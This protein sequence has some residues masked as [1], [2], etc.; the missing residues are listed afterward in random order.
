MKL[1]ILGT[2]KIVQAV[3]P[4]MPELK[5]PGSA[6]LATKRSGERARA[7][8]KDY[9]I[10]QIFFDYEELL[11]SDIDTVYVAL[12]NHLH[13]EFAKKA[14]LAGKHV[15]LEKPAA[16]TSKELRNLAD[17]A[18]EHKVYILEATNIHFMPAFKALKE[19][20]A[21]IGS[22]RIASFNY[23]QYSSRYE[24]FKNGLVHPVFDPEK[25]GGSLMDINFYNIE[26]MLSLFGIPEEIHYSANIER[27]IDT[28]GI[29]L[30]D[31]P[32]F[33]AVCIGA[34]D[35]AARASSTIQGDTATIE[36][37]Q[38]INFIGSYSIVY[39]DGHKE[40]RSFD[41]HPYRW[42]YEFA[43]FKRIIDEHDTAEASRL[44]ELPLHTM[45]I[46]DTARRKAGISL[47]HC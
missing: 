17:L 33:K 20:L 29:L 43:E 25:A 3:L 35:S 41:Q 9:G 32:H 8:A 19:D 37:S 24:D 11:A 4:F 26:A 31:Y 36:I 14:V 30:A 34:K 15:I 2:G 40:V 5:L 46:L 23:S 16:A 44:L 38:P 10:G 47:F 45:E 18:F 21:K 39:H 1:G 6:L 28:S 7:L 22:L 12:P 13:F 27:G 42:Y